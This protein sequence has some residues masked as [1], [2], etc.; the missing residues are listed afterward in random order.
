MHANLPE[1]CCY[2]DI[3]ANNE[4]SV[5]PADESKQFGKKRWEVFF[6]KLGII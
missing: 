3:I 4:L 5:I 1:V 2:L 6:T